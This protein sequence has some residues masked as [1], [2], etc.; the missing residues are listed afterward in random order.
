M[1]PHTSIV[2]SNV[3]EVQKNVFHFPIFGEIIPKHA[4]YLYEQLF[5]VKISHLNF[6][7]LSDRVSGGLHHEICLE[8]GVLKIYCRMLH[9]VI[10]RQ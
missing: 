8:E 5:L 9:V 6:L 2:F 4:F 7:Q 1:R 3:F 10:L